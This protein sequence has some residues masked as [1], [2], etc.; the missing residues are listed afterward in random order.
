MGFVCLT[1][2]LDVE[3]SKGNITAGQLSMTSADGHGHCTYHAAG[4]SLHS[5]VCGS[6]NPNPNPNPT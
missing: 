5:V 3:I 2:V 4:S 6:P 1:K